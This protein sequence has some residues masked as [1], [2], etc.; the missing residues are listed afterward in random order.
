M[1]REQL[2]IKYNFDN[3]DFLSYLRVKQKFLKECKIDDTETL[4][5]PFIPHHINVIF[6]SKKG[7]HDFY[8]SLQADQKNNHIMKQSWN[9]DINTFINEEQWNLIFGVCL[10]TLQNNSLIW[11]QLKILCRILGTNQYLHKI[12]LSDSPLCSRC[13]TTSES[14]LHLLSQCNESRNF[15]IS[16][17]NLIYEKI[18]LRIKFNDSNIIHGYLSIDHNNIPL[19]TLII[20]A[21][22]YISDS[23]TSKSRL[24]IMAFR[25]KFSNIY[26]EESVV[27]KFSEQEAK[28]KKPWPKW[29]PLVET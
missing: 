27:S 13:N 15:W 4:A 10:K 9:K 12:G 8:E 20:T 18:K 25:H 7:A 1:S 29:L 19:N 24:H 2:R 16:L 22:K 17:E 23:V 26:T 11:F 3:I 6:K 14:I 28:F 5:R 21:K